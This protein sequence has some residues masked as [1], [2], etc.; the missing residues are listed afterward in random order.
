MDAA[1]VKR[2][3]KKEKESELLIFTVA[4]YFLL[5]TGKRAGSVG[6]GRP[7]KYPNLNSE[8]QSPQVVQATA[9]S[10]TATTGSSGGGLVDI[11][12]QLDSNKRNE[13]LSLVGQYKNR[14]LSLNDF[15]I[16][17]RDLLGERLYLQ[18]SRDMNNAA[19][20]R[21]AGNS[22]PASHPSNNYPQVH[23]LNMMPPPPMGVPL[24]NAPPSYP[25][26]MHSMPQIYGP[27]P[28][29]QANYPSLPVSNPA[30]EVDV[31]K[32]DTSSL[33]D[34]M[35]YS[36]VDLK[37]E[38][39]LLYREHDIS[40]GLG[41]IG[42]YV[43]HRL[44]FDYFFNPFKF[45]AIV[46]HALQ[47][48]FFSNTLNVPNSSD[49]ST[50]KSLNKPLG[51]TEEAVHLLGI[52]IQKRLIGILRRLAEISRH[53]VDYSRGRFKIK[54]ENDP[55]KQ[56]WL[57]EKLFIEGIGEDKRKTSSVPG[58]PST[59][60]T[61]SVNQTL[62]NPPSLATINSA[63]AS[64]AAANKATAP[65]K[66]LATSQAT[67]TAGPSGNDDSV[68][69]KLANVTALAAL[70]I[71]Q[72]SW[73]SSA[74]A[75]ASSSGSTSASGSGPMTSSTQQ[76]SSNESSTNGTGEEKEA[77]EVYQHPLANFYSLPSST[78]LT[79]SELRA[80]YFNR[81]ISTVDLITCME[82]DPHLR[83]SRLLAVLYD[84]LPRENK[85]NAPDNS[86]SNN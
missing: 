18:L 28:V 64:A 16:K 42:A 74:A 84:A 7:P 17:A 82:S 35:Q 15:M 44:K 57:Q 1:E 69:T 40:G 8:D 31:T 58:T 56:I 77:S 52:A 67:S 78:P 73:M 79:D 9:S 3:A 70:G 26:P 71:R 46:Q 75:A 5:F 4:L 10:T 83:R 62:L 23:P 21:G 48:H 32:M 38:A 30:I 61:A 13:M 81:T 86:N 27:A 50:G 2:R 12:N 80:Q 19:A 51:I 24:R 63:A 59:S 72:K 41:S 36:G 66:T 76:G 33:Q 6:P 53:R 65:Q 43:D 85:E 55:K 37:A 34:V 49:S 25:M 39:E 47:R 45:R 54:I 20:A 60:T 11:L 22:I 29:L 14:I 68:K